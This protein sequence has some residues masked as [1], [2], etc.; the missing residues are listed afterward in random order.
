V[1]LYADKSYT[2]DAI[3]TDATRDDLL[4]AFGKKT[5]DN[6]YLQPGET[7]QSLF[8]RVAHAFGNDLAHSQRIYDYMSRL[9]FMPATPILANGGTT[10]GLPISCFLNEASDSLE[11]VIQLWTE[12]AWLSSRGGG[13]GSC[14]GNVRSMNEMLS[15]NGTAVGVMPFIKVMESISLS[16]D[17]GSLRRGAAAAYLPI[18]HPEIEEFLEMRNPTGGDHNRKSLYLHHGVV[19]TDDFMHCV[20]NDLTWDL[21]SP[22]DGTVK[23]TVSAR[24]LWIR[25]LTL[26]LETGEPYILYI[27]TINASVPAHHKQQDLSVKMSNL[28]TEITLPT[29]IDQ[30]GN[31]RTAVCCLSSLNIEYFKQWRT[32]SSFIPDI[33]AFLDNVLSAF[34]D[35]APEQM[36]RAI[37]SATQERSVGLGAMGFHAFLQKENIALEDKQAAEWNHTIFSHIAEQANQAS[38]DLATERGPC[39]DARLV[40]AM[41]R[42]SYKTAIAP[43]ASISII[44]GGTSPGIEPVVSNAYTHKTL[45]GSFFVR[46]PILHQCFVNKGLSESDIDALWTSI[47]QKGTVQHVDILTDQEKKVFKT[48]FEIDQNILIDL[49]AQ[50]QPFICQS[51]S[52]NLFLDSSVEKK[53][54]HHVH[55]NAWKKGIKS[56]YYM[57]SRSIQRPED[58]SRAQDTIAQNKAEQSTDKTKGLPLNYEECQVCQ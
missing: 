7:Y 4:T 43:T 38:I 41:Q 50:R 58:S 27:D 47:V 6:Q 30:H 22:K 8:A 18:S 56:L 32:E 11:S 36:H 13:I 5:M 48:A 20:A 40:D 17:Q 25:L 42:F 26:R 3:Q 12:N 21:V 31:E 28:C 9:W 49:A 15:N 16:I 35:T 39:P 23:N 52:L 2:I 1:P 37:Y 14:W 57:R 24:N 54:L 33:M 51:Q 53:T 10:R 34:I 46:N 44:C 19:I 45:S 55:F 29:G